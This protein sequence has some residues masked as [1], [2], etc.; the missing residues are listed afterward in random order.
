MGFKPPEPL[1]QLNQRKQCC[2]LSVLRTPTFPAYMGLL[3]NMVLQY[4]DQTTFADACF[5]R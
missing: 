5:A 1:E 4:L 2:I 3:G